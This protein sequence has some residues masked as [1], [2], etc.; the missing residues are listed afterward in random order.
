MKPV[1]EINPTKTSMVHIN[2]PPFDEFKHSYALELEEQ[3]MVFPDGSVWV[4]VADSVD[5]LPNTAEIICI[6][7]DEITLLE[8]F[9]GFVLLRNAESRDV[10]DGVDMFFD[11]ED[12]P[13]SPGTTDWWK[14]AQDFI[15]NPE[16]KEAYFGGSI[17][18]RR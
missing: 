18:N 3:L 6:R 7:H 5:N 15:R 4:N 1:S 13:L 11:A 14:A 2:V 10:G 12:N 9:N 16:V 8:T 17:N